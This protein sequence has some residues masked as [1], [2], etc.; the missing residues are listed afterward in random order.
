ML[1]TLSVS[2]CLS[3]L[4][5]ELQDGNPPPVFAASTALTIDISLNSPKETLDSTPSSGPLV[6]TLWAKVTNS[7]TSDAVNVD[8]T[9]GSLTNGLVLH[10]GQAATNTIPILSAGSSQAFFWFVGYSTADATVGS[11]TVTA[12]GDNTASVQANSTITS[13]EMNTNN[14]VKV[15]SASVSPSTGGNGQISVGQIITLSIAF[16]LGQ[17]GSGGDAWFQPVG[18]TSFDPTVLRL[19]SGNVTLDGVAQTQ[20]ALYFTGLN[21]KVT[22]T[23]DFIFQGIGVGTVTL[24]PYEQAAS[25]ANSVYNTDFGVLSVS[26]TDDPFEGTL[27]LGVSPTTGVKAGT[28]LTY[29][30]TVGNNGSQEFGDPTSGNGAIITG[31]IPTNTTYVASSVASTSTFDVQW[32]TDG[33]ATWVDNEPTASSVTD[34]RWILKS[35]VPAS[36]SDAVNDTFQVTVNACTPNNTTITGNDAISVGSAASVCT[37]SVAV[38][39]GIPDADLSITKSDSPDPVVVGSNLTYTLTVATDC[40]TTGV[41]VTDTL[42][43]TITLVSS[44]PSQGTCSGTSTVTCPLGALADAG[45]AT[46]TIV[47]TPTDVTALSNSASVTGDRPD[48]SSGNNSVVEG[49][50]VNPGALTSTNVEPESLVAGAVGDVDVSFTLVNDLAVDGKIVVT[51][52]A[53]FTLSSGATTD[54]GADGTSFDGS[55]SVSISGQDVTITRSEGSVVTGGTVVT[56]ELTNIKNPTVSGSAGTYAIKT[57]NSSDATGDEDAAVSADTITPGALTSADVEPE[58]LVASD[59]GDVD[60]T[61][62]LANPLPADGKI[63]VTLPAGFTLS[64]GTATD[65]GTDGTSFDGSESVSISGQVAT[66]TRSGGTEVAERTVVTLELTNIKNPTSVGSSGTYTIKTTNT[67]DVTIDQDTT[68]SADNILAGNLTST[69]VEPESLV[70]GAVGDVDVSFTLGTALDIGGKIVIIF[71]VGNQQKWDTF[72]KERSG[73]NGSVVGL[74]EQVVV[75]FAAG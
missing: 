65:I 73:G 11:Y 15:T 3:V 55:E 54:I 64:S 46:V 21:G 23:A 67:S 25:G 57:T 34:L 24:S 49:T 38:T 1:L 52:P 28:T 17:I 30:M 4:V 8:V 40:A 59:V 37:G 14:S 18:N 6:A 60:V 62:T 63:V 5:I 16:D 26:A 74:P 71:P 43:S 68:V 42:P 13:T 27:S 75:A 58:S 7:G 10:T 19:I 70:A 41:T 12:D 61:F 66:I 72:V 39:T 44:T 32:S 47:I 9:L 50:T 29:T 33:E 2:T 48:P 36:T 45:N 56:L 20:D 35:A 51:L 22:G 31:D 53:G 69:N